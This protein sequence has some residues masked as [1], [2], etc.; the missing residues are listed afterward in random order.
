MKVRTMDKDD[1]KKLIETDPHLCDD[2]AHWGNEFC[3]ECLEEAIEDLPAKKKLKIAKMLK[4]F[5]RVVG[6]K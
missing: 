6:D 4:S 3:M 1:I 2:C 5:K